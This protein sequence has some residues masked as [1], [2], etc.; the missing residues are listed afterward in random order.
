MRSYPI[1]G[2]L[3]GG[4]PRAAQAAGAVYLLAFFRVPR[5]RTGP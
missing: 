4:G 3:P 5:F 2:A 1:G